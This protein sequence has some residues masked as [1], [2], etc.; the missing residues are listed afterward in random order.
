ML[1]LTFSLKATSLNIS[2]YQ[3]TSGKTYGLSFIRV[4]LILSGLYKTS[5]LPS[6]FT[7]SLN[8]SIYVAPSTNLGVLVGWLICPSTRKFIIGLSRFCPDFVVTIITPF[9]PR[10]PYIA[11][12]VA[13]FKMENPSITSGSKAFKSA[14]DTCTPSMIIRGDVA[15]LKVE[16]PRIQKSDPSA[17]GRP[18]R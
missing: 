1:K 5:G 13:S 10:V 4:P 3:F 14:E 12:A 11:V 9:A 8:S 7:A 6:F 16:I 18:V 15:S 2:S 17:P